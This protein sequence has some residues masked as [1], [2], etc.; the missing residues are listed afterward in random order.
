MRKSISLTL[1]LLLALLLPGGA[2]AAGSLEISGGAG[3]R[4]ELVTVE[5]RLTGGKDVHAGNFSISYDHDALTLERADKVGT[6]MGAVNPNDSQGNVRVSIASGAEAIPDQVL[7]TLTFLVRE[8]ASPEGST[9]SVE[10]ARFYNAEGDPAEV[11]VSVGTIAKKCVYFHLDCADTVEAQSVRAEVSMD[12]ELHPAGG[13]FTVAYDAA[14]LEPTAVL[15]LD[16][17][18]GAQL[19]S[20]LSIPGEVRIS[21]AGSGA[22]QPGRLCAVIFRTRGAAGSESTLSLKDVRAYDEDS[23]PVDHMVAGGTVHIVMP[24]DRDPKLWVVGGAL[25]EGRATASVLLQGRGIVCGGQFTL[26]YG[27]GVTVTAEPGAG[28]EIN[29]GDGM[30]QV[31]WAAETPPLDAVS[32]VTLYFTNAQEGELSFDENVRLYDSGGQ[33]IGVVDIRPGRLTAAGQVTALAEG[34][35]QPAGG[36]SQVTVELDLADINYYTQSA[37]AAATPVLAVYD[38]DGRLRGLDLQADVPFDRGVLETELTVKTSAEAAAYQVFVLDSA[39]SA[40]PLCGEIN[41]S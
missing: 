2:F 35:I 16:S 40:Q 9:L 8:G 25:E 19:T 27:A 31:T 39:Q 23:G 20:N 15:P 1:A 4:G 30:L 5:V 37:R 18:G 41:G 22:L 17:A 28:V 26:L 6:W 36:S 13:N 3:K 38:S 32:L 14:A 29:Q 24:S 11:S 21:F 7:L 34:T 12:G 33:Q 10:N